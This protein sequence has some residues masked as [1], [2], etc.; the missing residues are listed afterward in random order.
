MADGAFAGL[1]SPA[2]GWMELFQSLLRAADPVL[3]LEA[4]GRPRAPCALDAAL[5]QRWRSANAYAGCRERRRRTVTLCRRHHRHGTGLLMAHEC[6]AP[7][8]IGSACAWI[9]GRLGPHLLYG[10]SLERVGEC[11]VSVKSVKR[12]STMCLERA[13]YLFQN[14]DR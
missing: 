8:A 9:L 5:S 3:P 14:T 13:L 12:M 2:S 1:V 7:A 6:T 4:C 11:P 10:C